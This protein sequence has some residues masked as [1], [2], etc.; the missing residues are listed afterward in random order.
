[1]VSINMQTMTSHKC[2]GQDSSEEIN[3]IEKEEMLSAYTKSQEMLSNVETIPGF[4]TK[5]SIALDCF[6]VFR[7]FHMQS[8]AISSAKM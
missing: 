1:M 4:T 2:G 8:D 5:K 7:R 6:L 3:V